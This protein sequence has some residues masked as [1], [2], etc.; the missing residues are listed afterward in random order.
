MEGFSRSL[1][2]RLALFTH[3]S[4]GASFGK[5]KELRP[6]RKAGLTR[7]GASFKIPMEHEERK[8]MRDDLLLCYTRL[9]VLNVY[10]DS[11]AIYAGTI[12]YCGCRT[13]TTFPLT[14]HLQDG[15]RGNL[16]PQRET[17]EMALCL[18]IGVEPP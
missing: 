16:V 12:Q 7:S 4:C 18:E 3:T 6:R 10:P 13:A 17:I 11:L 9:M 2:N 15:R 1:S 14:C 8:K 5:L